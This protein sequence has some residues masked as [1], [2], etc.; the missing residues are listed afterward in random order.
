MPMKRNKE[1]T[2]NGK[3]AAAKVQEVRGK[4]KVAK[5]Q[6]AAAETTAKGK[7]KVAG[8]AKG[9]KKSLLDVK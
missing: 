5:V 9:K 6:R 4:R 2:E 8:A 1:V 3:G 7:E